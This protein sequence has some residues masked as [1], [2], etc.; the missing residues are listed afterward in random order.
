MNVFLFIT[1]RVISSE[2]SDRQT[3][4]LRT[5]TSAADEATCKGNAPVWART[6]ASTL[7]GCPSCSA[8]E[9]NLNGALCL[10][11]MFLTIPL[12]M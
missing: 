2:G 3:T 6:R 9:S 8:K 1:D 7:P 5:A 11:R 12:P 10:H 4:S